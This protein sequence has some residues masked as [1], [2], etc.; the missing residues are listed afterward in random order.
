M[1]EEIQLIND[2]D[3]LAVIGDPSAVDR[4]LSSEG[5]ES[6]DLGL[7]RLGPKLGKAA[8]IMD[9]GSQV[10]A[11]S[12]RWVKLTDESA[13]AIKKYGLMKNSKSGLSMGVVQAKGQSGGIKAIVQFTSGPASKLANPALLAG[14]AGIMAQAA[15]QQT[16]DEITDYLAAI[17]EKVDDILRAQKD[18]VLADMLGVDFVIEEALTIREEVGRVSEVTWSKVQAT[19]GTIGRTQ[20]YA[21][22]QLEVLAEKLEGKTAVGDL[23]KATREAEEKV[24]EW[25]AVL[26]RCFQLQDALNVLELDRVLEAAPEDLDQHRLGLK[27]ARRRRTELIARSTD[28]LMARL[29][30]AAGTANAKVLLNPS[31][32][33]AVV[34]FSNETATGIAAFQ[35][36]L[37][38]D[39]EREALEARQWLDAAGDAKD[40]VVEAGTDSVDAAKRLGADGVDAARRL[41]AETKDKAK[42]VSGKV[43]SRLAERSSRW[44]RDAD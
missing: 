18:A 29:D 5:L 24:R 9:V 25:L 6:K 40:R 23:A 41:G 17:D 8:G 15:M 11:N 13:R 36:L 28:R 32:S 37:G 27:S 44:R 26:A 34:K 22:R 4:F 1:D 35:G 31:S 39:S 14:A 12:G 43:A 16:M 20:A 30:A 2:G 7:R 3:G 10:A 38:I 21:L 19:S 42:S 33:R